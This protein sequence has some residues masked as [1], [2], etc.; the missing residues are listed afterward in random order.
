MLGNGELM[1]S[2]ALPTRPNPILK[3]PPPFIELVENR[4][5]G[6]TNLGEKANNSGP[7]SY[8]HLRIPLP[9]NLEGQELFG[10]G[11]PESYFLMRRSKDGFVSS[12]G[13]FKAS[14]PWA[15]KIEEE[16][17]K[18][19][20]KSHFPNTS[21]IET[22]G[23]LWVD[24]VDALALAEE[25]GI[26]P[27][28]EALLDNETVLP[29]DVRKRSITPPPAF[30][31]PAESDAGSVT[32]SIAPPPS[33]GT[34]RRSTRSM[35]PGKR[36]M[37]P[38]KSRAS[39][40]T[41]KD[42][43]LKKEVT[44]ILEKEE[45]Q[46]ITTSESTVLAATTVANG[47]SDDVPSATTPVKKDR[48]KIEVD[49]EVET[50]GDVEKKITHVKLELPAG[51]PLSAESTEEMIAKAREMVL[52]ARK[53]EGEAAPS[54]KRKADDLEDEEM[55]D[56]EPEEEEESEERKAKRT[57]VLEDQLRKEKVKNRALLGL[58]ATLAI[59]ALLPYVL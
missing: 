14:F 3:S 29:S 11:A 28:I 34:R 4:R 51:E 24:P 52:E 40:A 7:F 42:S 49:E 25:Y 39:K 26:K 37:T 1:Y 55:E 33:A 16:A 32:S 15:R 50:S 44:P 17:E 58:S 35:S 48:L 43:P 47:T 54:I 57:R 30:F 59:G 56:A 23:N 41:V 9:Q 19:Y 18:Q 53:I 27:W 13:M 36:I 12:T 21:K 10:A 38:R 2:R 20:V 46:T 5:L 6:Q 22:A 8:V 31:R 45:T